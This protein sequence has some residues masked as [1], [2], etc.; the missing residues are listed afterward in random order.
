MRE[1]SAWLRRRYSGRD[2]ARA[3]SIADLQAMAHNRLPAFVTEYLEGG[4]E[5]ESTLAENR[6]IFDRYRFAPR[7]LNGHQET[8]ATT[9]LGKSAALPLVVAPTG[10][11]GLLWHHGDIELAAAAAAAGIPFI[12]SMVSGSTVAT[13]A[14]TPAL[15][16][17]M[18][19]YALRDER[20]VDAI[21]DDAG[22]RGCR[23]LI[24]TVDANHYGN[25]EWNRRLY[26]SESSLRWPARFDAAM[27]PR[28]MMQVFR[29]G[30][31]GFPNVQPFVPEG[32][33]D[34]LATARWIRGQMNPM[35]HWNDIARL[36]RRW[37]G[38]LLIKGIGHIEDAV[39][40]TETGADGLI[41]SNHGGR[42][43]DGALPALALLAQTRDRL[44][45]QSAIFIDGGIRRGSD[46]LKAR[47]LGADGV[48]AGRA[49]L[50]GLAAAGRAGVSRAVAILSEEYA[51]A[52]ALAGGGDLVEDRA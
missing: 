17:W 27:H 24:V 50:Y 28:W 16:H 10:L 43:L 33:R 36:R 31:P 19:L 18:Q 15:D 49:M 1:M 22:Q 29:R 23:V 9:L 52:C 21:V 25:R 32:A 47:M 13:I 26:R 41:L 35:L 39:K 48:L 37:S 45:P 42:Q 5:D 11:N 2:P 46:I 30:I 38:P 3:V 20:A 51:L 14:E 44:G 34:M 40:A 4:A 8:I 7:V 6:R 12:Q